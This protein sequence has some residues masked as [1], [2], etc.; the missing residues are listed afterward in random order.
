MPIIITKHGKNAEKIEKSNFKNERYLQDYIYKNPESLPIYQI[1]DNIRVLISVREFPTVSGAIDAIGFDEDGDIYII[2][3]KLYKNPDKRQ[4]IAQVLDYGAAL[5]SI[6]D[7]EE[8]LE[9]ISSGIKENFNVSFEEKLAS[10]FNIDEDGIYSLQA[11]L[12]SNLEKGKFKFIVLMDKIETRLKNLISFLNSNSSFDVYGVEL[13]YYKCNEFEIMIPKLYGAEIRK[14]VGQ[15]TGEKRSRWDRNRFLEAAKMNLSEE[16]YKVILN[17]L[18]F[19]EE[20]GLVRYGTGT[21]RGSFN[22]IVENICTRSLYSIYTDGI[23]SLNFPWIDEHET[24]RKY[25][26]IYK[27][28]V[29]EESELNIPENYKEKFPTYKIDEWAGKE[30]SFINAIR[31]LLYTELD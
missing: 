26:D 4:V 29:T 28:I 27:E 6:N 22:F 9:I 18:N 31:K 21:I 7:F 12:R 16:H 13:E 19:S 20:N 14:K 8:F 11:E 17:I 3:T 10:F 5:S 15:T 25:R 24:M 1:K 23:L 30:K 2:E